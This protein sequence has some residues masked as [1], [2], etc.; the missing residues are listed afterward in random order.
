[1]TK[2]KQLKYIIKNEGKCGSA[3]WH[4]RECPL[5]YVN[6]SLNE[7]ILAFAKLKLKRM[8]VKALLENL[9]E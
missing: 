5:K 1:M 9:D 4:C 8:K 7:T 3:P 2:I 6:C